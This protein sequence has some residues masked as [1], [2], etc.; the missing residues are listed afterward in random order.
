MIGVAV[1]VFIAAAA[2]SAGRFSAPLKVETRDVEHVVYKDKIVEV[3]KI[4][5]VKEKAKVET[6]VVYRDRVITKDGTV[7]E[8]E[9]ERTETKKDE[10]VSI[11]DNKD[12]TATLTGEKT[13]EHTQT[14]TLRP[15]WRVAVLV[16][17]QYP[18]PL[19]PIAGPLVLGAIGEYR[20]V[21]GLSAGLWITT[22]LAGG[23]IVSFEF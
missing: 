2:F 19:A 6:R 10:K 17:A 12:R 13:V 7:T 16:G 5:T 11:V 14:V 20:I 8:H 4:V 23:L 21:G 15:N 18:A 3:E 9:V 1:I 22:G